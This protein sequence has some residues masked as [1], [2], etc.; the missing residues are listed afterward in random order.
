MK[1]PEEDRQLYSQGDVWHALLALLP[2]GPELERRAR[3]TGAFRRKRGVREATDLLRVALSYGFCGLSFDGASAW[4]RANQSAK[5]CK[6]AVIRR[7]RG[8]G[9]WLEGLLLEKLSARLPVAQLGGLKVRIVDATRVAQPGSKGAAWRV[10][11]SYDPVSGK[12][13]ELFVS[14]HKGGERLSRF[15]VQPGE[16]F[17]G[18]R[19]YGTRPGIAHVVRDGGLFLVRTTWHHTPLE[20]SD[21]GCF[22]LFDVLRGLKDGAV[23]DVD[24]RVAPDAR[25]GFEAVPCRL[26]AVRKPAAAADAAKKRILAEAKKK[27]HKVDPRT[28]EAC[29]YFFVLTSVSRHAF[30][31]QA[32][33]SLYRLRWQIEVEFKRLKSLLR[34]KDLRAVTRESIR[35]ALAAKLLG[36]VLIQELLDAPKDGTQHWTLSQALYEST[37][38]AILGMDAAAKWLTDKATRVCLPAPDVRERLP[39][40]LALARQLP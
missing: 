18:D 30:D 13:C 17:V 21:G 31:G 34:L 35:A 11:A 14:D 1:L 8:C 32:V 2:P 19:S 28:L 38:Q 22:D 27:G 16:L 10:H 26:V 15:T 40:T 4:A 20:A 7:L 6:A 36:A 25:H 33:L 23:G 9:E 39:Q 29:E 3:T 24:I 12:L 5:L 37:R